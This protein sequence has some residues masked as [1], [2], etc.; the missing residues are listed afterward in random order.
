MMKT[1][2]LAGLLALLKAENEKKNVETYDYD[3]LT[4]SLMNE[5][6]AQ[7][8][9]NALNY[10]CH[11][12]DIKNIAVT[13]PYGAGK[14]SV[15][16]TW[17][18][19]RENDLKIMTV[20][21]A[22]FD[23]IRATAETEEK[24]E[25]SGAKSE[26][27]AKQQE[28][29]I[30]YSI[31]QQILYK[32]RKS[33]LPYSRIERI[34]DVTPSQTRKMAWDLLTTVGS[35]LSGL[36][37][38]F[39]AY[40]GKKLSLPAGFSETILQIPSVIR[41]GLLA[42]SAFFITFYLV[43]SKLHRI[44]IFD[45]R[46]SI[47]KIDLSKGATI[48]TRPSDPSLLNV[49]IDEIVYFFEKQKY[50]VVIFED[51]DRHNDGAI[52][53]KLREINQII[54]NCRPVENPVRFIYA[55]RDDIFNS[56]EARTKFFDFVM[57]VIPV[58]DSQNATDHF[59][60]KFQKNELEVPGFEQCIAR[61]AIFIPDMRVLNSISNEFRLYRN[62]VN[63]G[64]NIIRLISL[65]AYKNICSRDYHLIDSKQGVLYGV[66]NAHISGELS[67][68]FEARINEEI[69]TLNLQASEINDELASDKP[70]VI[71]DILQVYISEKTHRQAYFSNHNNAHYTLHSVINNEETFLSMLKTPG[72]HVR[73]ST[74]NIQ[75]AGIDTSEAGEI[76]REY[77]RRCNI[78]SSKADGKLSALE[79]RVE[80]LRQR[81][82]RLQASRPGTLIER[83][84]S[85]GF[86]TWVCDNLRIECGPDNS[87]GY[88]ASQLDFIYSLLR[89]GYLSTDY[90]AYRSVFIPGSLSSNDNEFIRAVSAGMD[91]TLTVA[92]PL[93]KTANVIAKLKE[94]GLLLQDNAWHAGVLRYLHKHDQRKLQEVIQIQLEEGEEHR[95]EQLYKQVFSSW[96]AS[97][98]IA[99]TQLMAS[100]TN[101]AAEFLNRLLKMGDKKSA[102]NLLVLLFCSSEPSW[103]KE[104]V[105]IRY[106]ADRI[107][108]EHDDIPDVVPDNYASSFTENLMR[109]HVM[110]SR[111]GDCKSEQGR[112]IVSILANI[113]LWKYSKDNLLNMVSI[114][115]GH[116]E[117]VHRQFMKEPF[118]TLETFNIPQ[119]NKKIKQSINNFIT[120]FFISS[121]E[122][123]RVSAIL[124]DPN[125]SVNNI[126]K[127]A[128]E[129]I[130]SIPDVS[131]INERSD[132]FLT[133]K[134]ISAE[135]SIYTLLLDNNR[136]E[137]T[138]RNVCYL[139][140][141][142]DELNPWLAIWFE[143]NYD[144]IADIPAALSSI[145][146]YENLI[147]KIYAS[148]ALSDQARI[149]ILSAIQLTLLS[150]PETLN[151]DQA[152][153]LID[154]GRLAPIRSVYQQLYT[155]FHEENHNADTLLAGLVLQH[156]KMLEKEPDFILIHGGDLDYMLARQLLTSK[157][158]PE[159][160]LT[161]TLQWLWGYDVE[162]FEGPLF[163][164]SSTLLRLSTLLRDEN[165]LR[166]LLLQ[167][168][169]AGDVTHN[170]IV[171]VLGALSDPVARA[172][173]SDLNHR[174]IDMSEEDL[175]LAQRLESAGFIRALK[176][177]SKE[178]RFRF[179]PHNSSAFRRE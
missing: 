113:D 64:E 162:L 66:M 93:E 13:G 84:G 14:S 167:S 170:V 4:P 142:S 109:T 129:M 54:N 92:M 82:R 160:V 88:N 96:P 169:K 80:H 112:E 38:L 15:L 83:M 27:K 47:D 97:E 128:R 136:I 58:M 34:A 138:W 5:E 39:P 126:E 110:L 19:C 74:Y 159:S 154:Y 175:E 98:S 56:P 21:L 107:F 158:L 89:W 30:E 9:V 3:A 95:L 134:N 121:D 173:I 63:N 41:I 20:S 137:S 68:I 127:L 57:P 79:E 177:E 145:D 130:F 11:Q 144:T 78:L 106:M 6:D 148:G 141:F 17:S 28:K 32:A 103:I 10:A 99:Y 18:K 131:K 71:R 149:K 100:G 174:S 146:I 86:R 166:A 72:L 29:S 90:M 77:E 2:R 161:S 69:K 91:H 171:Q 76:L 87:E 52:F 114:L 1:P 22:D 179:V 125:L 53:I 75:L 140:K 44:G 164:N 115:S 46:V 43:L 24:S 26:K 40:Y 70:E 132:V 65:I 55:V 12:Q 101:A 122:F 176:E 172:F 16:L 48:S 60:G 36:V 116:D 108:S 178:G 123:G 152:G 8:Y 73:A 37:L 153:L 117:T 35:G 168:L 61:L 7:H 157:D 139:L 23:M 45:R 119:L 118:S 102:M 25:E 94:L 156:P 81:R 49:F 62:L 59:S 42:S 67:S 105:E 104:A 135:T 31:L 163:I 133:Y 147:E 33:E 50:N 124:N 85:E 111:I 155:A 165:I 51:L 143:N 120:D 150:L 151:A